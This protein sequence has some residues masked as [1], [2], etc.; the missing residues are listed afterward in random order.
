MIYQAKKEAAAKK[1]LKAKAQAQKP[2]Q[3]KAIKQTHKARA[4]VGGKR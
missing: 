1:A 2:A 3:Q 4:Q